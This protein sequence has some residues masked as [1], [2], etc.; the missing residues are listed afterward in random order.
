MRKNMQEERVKTS[1]SLPKSIREELRYFAHYSRETES[2]IVEEAIVAY[3]S[4]DKGFEKIR[5]EERQKREF[6]ES[7]NENLG[8]PINFSPNSEIL[9]KGE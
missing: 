4:S 3:M 1:I 9:Y 8:K 5:E 2:A 7:L 6:F